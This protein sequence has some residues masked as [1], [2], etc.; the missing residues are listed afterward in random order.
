MPSRPIKGTDKLDM[1]P[2]GE[3]IHQHAGRDQRVPNH[4]D[5]PYG[6]IAGACCKI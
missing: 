3:E 2:P 6:V 1:F 5:S 4:N